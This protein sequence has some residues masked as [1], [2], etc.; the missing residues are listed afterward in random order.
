MSFSLASLSLRGSTL[1]PSRRN[2]APVFYC[3]LPGFTDPCYIGQTMEGTVDSAHVV[4]C[5]IHLLPANLR[6]NAILKKSQELQSLEADSINS[7]PAMQSGPTPGSSRN[8]TPVDYSIKQNKTNH[9]RTA[10]RMKPYQTTKR[11]NRQQQHHNNV[12]D[13]SS[14]P[15]G[16]IGQPIANA[17]VKKQRNA[18]SNPPLPSTSR[19]SWANGNPSPEDLPSHL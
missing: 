13:G 15:N 12:F 14:P 18:V 4:N 10:P 3:H 16:T 17:R 2:E 11:P 5:Y 8:N 9:P 19:P 6:R 7:A 1:N